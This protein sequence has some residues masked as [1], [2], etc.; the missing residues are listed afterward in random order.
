MRHLFA[1]ECHH[2]W[3]QSLVI[4]LCSITVLV[5]CNH[6][7]ATVVDED[8][9]RTSA[10]IPCSATYL[11]AD[12]NYPNML[13]NIFVST[14]S[15]ESSLSVVKVIKISNL[16]RSLE[17][18]GSHRHLISKLKTIES[19]SSSTYLD[20]YNC[21][22]V[23]IETLNGVF[24][25][26]FELQRLVNRKVYLDAAVFGDTNL[27]LPA[28]LSNSSFVEIH[29]DL[30]SSSKANHELV[31]QLPLH[32]RYPPLDGSAYS[33]IEISRPDLYIRCRKRNIDKDC[34]WG[35]SI[36]EL[37]PTE[38]VKWRIPCGDDAHS[39]I[40]SSVTFLSAL[41][42]ALS[43]VFASILYRP[44]IYTKDQ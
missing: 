17:G 44:T 6:G 23:I 10:C 18:E 12:P 2:C 5:L 39:T 30:A 29:M 37:G 27:E 31:V 38:K 32:V 19:D 11:A 43:I 21:E 13:S 15:C 22:L 20:R 25:D 16:H 40:V 8:N 28:A 36:R 41:V 1:N 4:Y 34:Q 35:V 33:N 26:P 9:Q 42:C 3:L 7:L 14:E 24:A